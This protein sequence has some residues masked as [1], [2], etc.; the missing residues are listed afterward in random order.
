MADLTELPR[1]S[2]WHG[3]G[4]PG[5]VRPLP[6]GGW[7]LLKFLGRE[8]GYALA[9]RKNIVQQRAIWSFCKK[10]PKAARRP[11]APGS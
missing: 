8:R 7:P 2:V 11:A 6:T 1:R 5:Q 3:W 9:R 10:H 4:D